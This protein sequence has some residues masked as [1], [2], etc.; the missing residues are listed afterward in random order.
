MASKPSEEPASL[1]LATLADVNRLINNM[2]NKTEGAVGPCFANLA[3]EWRK[4][5][6]SY[7]FSRPHQEEMLEF[8][9]VTFLAAKVNLQ[10]PTEMERRP[11]AL[12]VLYALYLK[13]PCTGICQI[14]LTHIDWKHFLDLFRYCAEN[15]LKE[16]CYIFEKLWR[17]NAFDF[18]YSPIDLSF[19]LNKKSCYE[20]LGI[21]AK[22]SIM[23]EVDPALTDSKRLLDE[24]DLGKVTEA[25]TA[26]NEMAKNISGIGP[27]S[28][29]EQL[30]A[31]LNRVPKKWAKYKTFVN[32]NRR[33]CVDEEVE[34]DDEERGIGERRRSLIL[35]PVSGED[36]ST[37]KAIPETAT[38]AKGRTPLDPKYS[39]IYTHNSKKQARCMS[40][41]LR[42]LTKEGRMDSFEELDD[43]E[44]EVGASEIVQSEAE[45]QMECD[46]HREVEDTN[47]EQVLEKALSM[48][49]V[50]WTDNEND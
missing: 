32:A 46:E 27:S 41:K 23:E 24:G 11:Y 7:I 15:D 29:S 43:N 1:F 48:P 17:L 50:Q 47:E 34:V 6:F 28:I 36:P 13:Q 3:E 40:E 21:V 45:E 33:M 14:R 25:Q 8:T 2:E 39:F 10:P 9:P 4:M 20:D 12:L 38:R 22:E 49:I 30:Q 19:L 16:Q 26:Y 44:M 18:V 37:E 35:R 5:R 31:I 42:K